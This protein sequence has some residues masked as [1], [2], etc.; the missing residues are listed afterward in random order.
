V[1]AEFILA[2][3]LIVDPLEDGRVRQA[4]EQFRKGSPF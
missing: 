1:D 4:L 3:Q 2:T